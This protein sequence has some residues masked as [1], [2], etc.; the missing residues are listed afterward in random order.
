[1][2]FNNPSFLLL[3]I[4]LTSCLGDLLVP[5]YPAPIDLSSED[6]L[7]PAAFAEVKSSLD[8][9]LNG[10]NTDE[11]VGAVED[12]DPAQWRIEQELNQRRRLLFWE[13][14]MNCCWMVRI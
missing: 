8:G 1:M 14:Y 2:L 10:S 12:R 6:S 13:T 5:T 3:S 9:Y 4:H 7:V 11:A